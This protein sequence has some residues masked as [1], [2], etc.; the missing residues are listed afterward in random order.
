MEDS[1]SNSYSQASD[2]KLSTTTKCLNNTW[3]LT[4]PGPNEAVTKC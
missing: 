4:I 1:E 3:K 2:S